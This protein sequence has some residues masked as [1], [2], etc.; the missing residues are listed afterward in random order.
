[1]YTLRSYTKWGEA[2]RL[3][4][5]C[6]C[7]DFDIVSTEVGKKIINR[8]YWE[9]QERFSFWFSR[10]YFSFARLTFSNSQKTFIFNFILE[11]C[12]PS[13][14]LMELSIKLND[15]WWT[16]R[17]STGMKEVGIWRTWRTGRYSDTQITFPPPSLWPFWP[18]GKTFQEHQS[19][20][21]LFNSL[22]PT[23]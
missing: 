1:M 11:K 23:Q 5:S 8:D 6:K 16:T 3:P 7:P 13:E 17:S 19:T 21:Y 22:S 20:R 15:F 9:T 2:F 10:S 14:F 4:K 18:A 12:S